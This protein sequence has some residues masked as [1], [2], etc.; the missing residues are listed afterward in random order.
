MPRFRMRDRLGQQTSQKDF[1]S[2]E[3]PVVKVIRL[4]PAKRLSCLGGFQKKRLSWA[5]N[6][7]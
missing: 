1:L 3:S 5:N 7:N 2:K 4:H 6:Q